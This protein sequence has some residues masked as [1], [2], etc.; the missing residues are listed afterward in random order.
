MKR[1]EDQEKKVKL[2]RLFGEALKSNRFLISEMQAS[3]IYFDA[4]LYIFNDLVIISKVEE[5][6]GSEREEKYGAFELN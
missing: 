5:L 2:D 6:L 4:K 1:I 3:T